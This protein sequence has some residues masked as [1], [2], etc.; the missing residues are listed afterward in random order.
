MPLAVFFPLIRSV[1][2]AMALRAMAECEVLSAGRCT[3]M[4]SVVSMIGIGKSEQTGGGALAAVVP[5]L[6]ISCGAIG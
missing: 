5:G 6:W 2:H 3:D 4:E 1:P